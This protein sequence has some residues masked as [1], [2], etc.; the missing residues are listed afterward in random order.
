[1]ATYSAADLLLKLRHLGQYGEVNL[2]EGKVVPSSAVVTGDVL[3]Y[4]RIP[5]GTEVHALVVSNAS[6]GGPAPADL[7]Y[8]PVDANEGSLAANS[9]Y[10]TSALALGTASN[11]TVLS[12][13]DAIKFEQD[14]YLIATFGTVVAGTTGTSRIKA[15]SRNVGV[16]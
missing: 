10:F 8:T 7:G 12:N 5:A 4:A 3:R 1:M 15:L 14:V 9:T 13:F 11:G 16:K 2:P 6:M